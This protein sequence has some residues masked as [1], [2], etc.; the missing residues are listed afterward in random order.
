MN[1][2]EINEL[3]EGMHVDRLE[4]LMATV[5]NRDQKTDKKGRPYTLQNAYLTQGADKIKVSFWNHPD[6]TGYRGKQVLLKSMPPKSFISVGKYK[7]QTQLSVPGQAVVIGEGETEDSIPMEFDKSGASVSKP[8]QNPPQANL[9]PKKA[10][11]VNGV[12]EVRHRVM[13][14]ANL[15]EICDH[16]A[17]FLYPD[18]SVVGLE[19]VKDIA[20]SLFIQAARENLH[21]K[22][23]NNKPLSKKEDV[24]ASE[25]DLEN[26]D[27]QF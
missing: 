4:A 3:G 5:F 12:Q 24:E 18:T 21:D 14:L 10:I 16:A 2:S 19:Y 1:I 11:P 26:D 27:I 8:Q 17:S 23:P 7:D 13:Q 9:A 20:T 25:P 15:R 22:L 6:L